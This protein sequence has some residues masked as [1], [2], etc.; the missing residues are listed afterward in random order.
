MLKKLGRIV[1]DSGG[2]PRAA[3]TGFEHNT[4]TGAMRGYATIAQAAIVP[5]DRSMQ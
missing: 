5:D 3:K 2:G 1:L 4:S